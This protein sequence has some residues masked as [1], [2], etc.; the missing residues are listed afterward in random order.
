MPTV[1]SVGSLC[2]IH[3]VL[4]STIAAVH[5]IEVHYVRGLEGLFIL[6]KFSDIYCITP[7][8]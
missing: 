4:R 7:E 1:T 6:G 5:G 8:T 3:A 2:K